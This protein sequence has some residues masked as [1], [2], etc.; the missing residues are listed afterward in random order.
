V[1]T[2]RYPARGLAG[3]RPPVVAR[4][5]EVSLEGWVLLVLVVVAAAIRIIT[6]DNQSFWADE[7]LT[8]YEAGQSFT[9]MLHTITSI[10][11]TPP[12]YFVLIWIWSKAFGTSEVALRSIS[13]MAGVATVP[14]AYLC[15]R[16]L[17]DRRAGLIAAAL[18][19]VNPFMIWYS[20]EARA[21][22]LLAALSGASFLWFLRA[23][24]D[25]SGRNLAWWAGFSAAALMTHFFAGFAIAPEA[26]W[27]LWACRSR[28]TV[29]AVGVVAA[30]QVAMLPFA[31][32]I[33]TRY[34][35][36]ELGEQYGRR[37]AV[38]GEML[39]RLRAEQ[40]VALRD[41]AD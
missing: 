38:E 25:R 31:I 17:I 3:H 34:M 4:L 9:A 24:R 12:L 35:G 23:G 22:M 18:V 39:V 8:A 27:L 6:I 41:I 28:A 1:S 20:Q 32:E 10:E 37:N 33:A 30:V 40:V 26:V 29:L 2:S 11:T 5:R 36:P 21:Y 16:E 14:I 13:A 19:A 15:A 7:A